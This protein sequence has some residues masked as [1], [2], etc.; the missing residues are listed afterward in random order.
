VELRPSVRLLALFGAVAIPPLVALAAVVTFERTWV[1]DV[2]TGT[3]LLLAVIG[4]AIWAAI[5]AVFGSRAFGRDLSQLL[6]IAER[7]VPESGDN[8]EALSTVQRRLAST[9]DERN[10]QIAS[11]AAA[12]SAIP[13]TATAVQV[14]ASV[15]RMARDVTGDPTWQLA[16]LKSAN[17]QLLAPGVYAPE[18]ATAQEPIG[19]MH[20]W[21]AA[22]EADASSAPAQGARSHHAIGPWGAFMVV[23][24]SADEQLTTILYAPR[25]GRGAPS[26]AELDLAALIGQQAATA[27]DHAILYARVRSQADELNRMAAV[28]TD[29]L[30]GV[31]HDLQTPLTSIRAVASE[32]GHAASLDAGARNDLDTIAHQADR[33]RRMVSQLLVAS[34]LEAGA[35][36][37]AQEV[38]R[39]EPLIRRTWEALRSGRPFELVDDGPPHLVVGDP[40]RLEQVL[41]AVLDNAV[42]YSQPGTGIR[43]RLAARGGAS[44]NG[45]MVGIVE[46]VDEGMGMSPSGVEHAFEQFFRADDARRVAP[47]G[48]GVGLY[49]ARGLM[50]AMGGDIHLESRLAQGTRVTLILPAETA[51]SGG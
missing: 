11:L 9:L 48:S 44:T 39:A 38:F 37:P 5:V 33:L 45:D 32:L 51:E 43:L 20:R 16:V 30:R 46:V 6:E 13:I 2:G 31:T 29:F 49:A 10:R 50:R 3:V 47:D 18:S 8:G 19:E 27:I 36:S 24:A 15:V 22:S 4:G 12:T 23:N 1:E 40:D 17:P 14:A 35:V 42:K 21:A 41:W 7:G 26:R 34:R 28:Q 25:E